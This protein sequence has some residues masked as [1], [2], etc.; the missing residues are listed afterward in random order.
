MKLVELLAQKEDVLVQKWLGL[1]LGEY[2]ADAVR[3]LGKKADQFANPLGHNYSTGVSGMFR[4][5]RVGEEF[6]LGPVLEQLMKV[7]AVQEQ[8]PSKSLA[9]LFGIKRIV[10]H[11]CRKEW[12]AEIEQEW[13]EFE[14]R[15]DGLALQAFDLFMASRERLFQVR[16]RELQSGSY[17][18]TDHMK[19]PSAMV[20]E[21]KKRQKTES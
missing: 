19:C 17:L 7:R 4:S 3:F 9:F 8:I 1:V 18:I 10:R 20:R 21:E 13:P 12:T 15:V 6:E 16:L 2:P 5:L 11:E 14:A